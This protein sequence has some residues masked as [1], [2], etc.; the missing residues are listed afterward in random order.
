MWQRI[1]RGCRTVSKA[2]VPGQ[3]KVLEN[4]PAEGERPVTEDRGTERDGT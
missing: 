2:T 1:R 3:E 4:T